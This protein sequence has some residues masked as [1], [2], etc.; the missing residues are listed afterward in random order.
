MEQEY[1]KILEAQVLY[2]LSRPKEAAETYMEALGSKNSKFNSETITEI[3]ANTIAAM[4]ASS[5][6][7]YDSEDAALKSDE[8]EEFMR[9]EKCSARDSFGTVDYSFLKAKLGLHR[10]MYQTV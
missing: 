7:M 6:D 5:V 1:S 8:A 3:R 2:R 10:E 4:T 9:S